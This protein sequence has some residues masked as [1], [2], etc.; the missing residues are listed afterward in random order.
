MQS[1]YLE[2]SVFSV[3]R[4]VEVSKVDS[5]LKYVEKAMAVESGNWRLAFQRSQLC[6]ITYS[7]FVLRAASD[8][9]K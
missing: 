3:T 1:V 9:T 2:K 5:K 8:N 4:G 6:K 7:Q